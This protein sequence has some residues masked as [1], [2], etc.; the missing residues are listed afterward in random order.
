VNSIYDVKPFPK[1]E[2]RYIVK[3]YCDWK[4]I[5]EEILTHEV[6]NC[7]RVGADKTVEAIKLYKAIRKVLLVFERREEE[8]GIIGKIDREIK[9]LEETLEINGRGFELIRN[10]QEISEE[11]RGMNFNV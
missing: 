2:L 4:G 5:L 3:N 9:K 10:A 6:P 7:I 8:E 11:I 1:K